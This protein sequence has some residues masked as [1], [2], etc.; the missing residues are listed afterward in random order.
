MFRKPKIEVRISEPKIFSNYN[1]NVRNLVPKGSNF[2]TF[3]N[4]NQKVLTLESS[5]LVNS[6]N[7]PFPEANTKKNQNME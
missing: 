7:L 1:L 5:K 3:Q 6:V 4:P 2:V